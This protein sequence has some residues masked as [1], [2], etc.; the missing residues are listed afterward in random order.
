MSNNARIAV[1]FGQFGAAAD[2]VNLPHFRDRLAQAGVETILVEHTD[3]KKVFDFLRGHNGSCAV[4]GASLGAGASPIFAGYLRGQ[5]VDFVGGFQPSDWDPVMHAVSIQSGVD[6]ITRA[7]TVP[8]NVRDALCFRNPVAATTGG[9]GHAT[10][11]LD[12]NNK[13]TKLTV[14][15]RADVHPG[16]FGEA[17]DAMFAAVKKAL[18]IA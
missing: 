16:D 14:V 13:T 3:S 18:A 8:E 11:V 1:V 4:V 17:Q 7:V 2:P 12:S 9:L 5:T 10:Y 6:L 15:E